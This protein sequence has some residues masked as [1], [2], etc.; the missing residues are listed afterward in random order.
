VGTEHLRLLLLN[1]NRI[2]TLDENP[3]LTTTTTATPA[4]TTA[5]RTVTVN[6]VDLPLLLREVAVTL[7]PLIKVGTREMVLQEGDQLVLPTDMAVEE[8]AMIATETEEAIEEREGREVEGEETETIE[9]EEVS[10]TFF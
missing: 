6:M 1:S 2:L 9:V 5:T 7:L 3:I 8:E 10:S 4:A